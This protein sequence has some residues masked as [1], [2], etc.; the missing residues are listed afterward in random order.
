VCHHDLEA[1]LLQAVFKRFGDERLV[2]DDQNLLCSQ[3]QA[4]LLPGFGT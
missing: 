2:V 3:D 1:L 4:S